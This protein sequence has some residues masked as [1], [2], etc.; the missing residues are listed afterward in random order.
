MN[1]KN[2]FF[3]ISLFVLSGIIFVFGSNFPNFIVRGQKLPGPKFFPYALAFVLIGLGV[4]F[5]VKS[6]VLLKLKK[7]PRDALLVPAEEITFDGVK[8]VI[9]VIAGILFFV[10]LINFLGFLL[11]AMVISTALMIILN[12]KIWRSL[13]YSVILVVLIFL[14]FGMVFKIPLPE[15]SLIAMFQG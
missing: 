14:I 13:I 9:A 5:I 2:I 7:A 12:V 3:G 8:N 10:P 1:I 6:I 4:Y 15:G 11:G